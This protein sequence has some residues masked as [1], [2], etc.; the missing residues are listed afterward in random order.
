[1]PMHLHRQH[2]DLVK[3]DINVVK[4]R[5]DYLCAQFFVKW[6]PD[7]HGFK[8]LAVFLITEGG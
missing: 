1:M 3:D 5:T 4:L 6:L 7:N 2:L 8:D